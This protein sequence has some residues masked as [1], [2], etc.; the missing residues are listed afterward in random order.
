MEPVRRDPRRSLAVQ[1]AVQ[2]AG[3][4]FTWHVNAEA[5]VVYFRKG[6]WP[7]SSG[8]R[9]VGDSIQSFGPGDLVMIGPNVP[10]TWQSDVPR[11]ASAVVMQF[12][13]DLFHLPDVPEATAVAKLLRSCGRGL[14]FPKPTRDLAARFDALASLGPLEAWAASL[15]ILGKLSR[16]TSVPLASEAF[17][18]RR[19]RHSD[20]DARRIDGVTRRCIAA[21][22]TG[23]HVPALDEAAASVSLTPAAFCRFFRRSTGTTYVKFVQRLRIGHACRLLLET[24]EQVTAIAMAC[25]FETTAHFNRLFRRLQRCTP[26]DYRR[27]YEFVK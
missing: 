21:V 24:D 25:G 6:D 1:D 5:E 7:G 13:L 16:L 23:H 20:A 17:T 18:Q 27:Q 2:E 12:P 3:Y 14:F 22:Q 4:Q 19:V 10:H 11:R 9:F 15:M 26:T 8:R